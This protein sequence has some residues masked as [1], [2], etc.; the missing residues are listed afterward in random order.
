M[1]SLV[2]PTG[3]V[4]VF[5]QTAAPP[6]WTK[7]TSV[8]DVGLRLVSGTGGV[9]GGSTNF[10]SVHPTAQQNWPFNLSGVTSPGSTGPAVASAASHSH[11]CFGNSP[12]PLV[13]GISF[14]PGVPG[15]PLTGFYNGIALG[16][17]GPTG[18]SVAHSHPYGASAT[19]SVYLANWT[20][21]YV[22]VILASKK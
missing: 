18:N 14:I 5:R 10:S 19:G 17:T 20:L 12:Y 8:N 6:G 16:P 11:S 15:T 2:F 4:T 1:G 22:D 9:L 21:R 3:T 7:L 13:G